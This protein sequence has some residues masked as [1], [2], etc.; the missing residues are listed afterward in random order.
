MARI[1]HE[2]RTVLAILGLAGTGSAALVAS[3]RALC[4]NG[5]S[6]AALLVSLFGG[7]S[8][9]AWALVR[10]LTGSQQPDRRRVLS[11]AEARATYDALGGKI[12]D[13]ESAYGGPATRSLLGAAELGSANAVFEFGCGPGR[14]ARK[15]FDEELPPAARYV[16]VDVSPVMVALA[17]RRL[18]NEVDSGRCEVLLTDGDPCAPEVRCQ[19]AGAF[20]AVVCTY[21]LD[22]LAEEDALAVLAEAWRMLRPGGRLCISGIT[23]GK[24]VGSSIVAGLW[25]LVHWANPATVGGCRHQRLVPYLEASSARGNTWRIVHCENI[26]G[27]GANLLAWLWSEVVVAVKELQ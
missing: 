23:Y 10:R 15:I 26:P 20:D 19:A 18:S 27:F 9:A 12:H 14:L 24:G 22:L 3:A 13:S 8:L 2:T 7:T 1:S 17:R 5:V 6:A 11:R 25:E 21:V 4:P 16:A